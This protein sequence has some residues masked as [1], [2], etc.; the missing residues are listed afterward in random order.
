MATAGRIQI[1]FIEWR[2]NSEAE[3]RDVKSLATK[4]QTCITQNPSSWK[5]EIAGWIVSRNIFCG[6]INS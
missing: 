6:Q 3:G 2:N 5:R 4:G 1:I